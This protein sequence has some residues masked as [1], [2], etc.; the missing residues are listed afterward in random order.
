MSPHQPSAPITLQ[1]SVSDP[2]RYCIVQTSKDRLDGV[3]AIKLPDLDHSESDTDSLSTPTGSP[4]RRPQQTVVQPPAAG[5]A[6]FGLLS[7]DNAADDQLKVRPRRKPKIPAP[8]RA[9]SPRMSFSFRIVFGMLSSFHYIS[10]GSKQPLDSV[11]SY[12]ATL[13]VLNWSKLELPCI[14][15]DW[16]Y[17]PGTWYFTKRLLRCQFKW[18]L[19]PNWRGNRFMK[20]KLCPSS[21]TLSSKKVLQTWI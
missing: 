16:C 3:K 1:I 21:A 13:L 11:C 10:A 9:F 17:A 19:A 14:Y 6:S 7:P 15:L 12:V 20:Y 18:L 5:G 2:D 4:Y 8:R